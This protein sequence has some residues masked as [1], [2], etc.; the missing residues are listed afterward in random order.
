M[1]N[2]NVVNLASSALAGLISR[3]IC[4]PIDT[5]K[6]KLQSGDSF[7]GVSDVVSK[8][9]KNEGIRGFYQGMGAAL[10]GG[11]PG[12]CIYISTYEASKAYLNHNAWMGANPFIS[13]L[14]SGMAAE[15]VCCSIFVPVDVVKER[16]QVQSNR[17]DSA[18]KGS[19]DAFRTIIKQ[20]GLRGLYKGYS[21]TLFSYGPFSATYFLLYEEAK[22]K[23]A[24]G[25]SNAELSFKENLACSAFAGSVASFLT[26]P[27]DLAKLRFQVQRSVP[28]AGTTT[29][30]PSAA[31][32]ETTYTGL[33]DVLSKLY[34]QNGV[35]G[36]FR[37]ALLRVLFFTP[38]TAL[39]MASY[40]QFKVLLSKS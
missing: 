20:E 3:L 31:T 18:Y 14:L 8:T 19:I 16:L 7:R 5:C 25:K 11:I 10:F 4:H 2:E 37:G 12:V 27:L 21:A 28:T 9:L 38:S 13:Y 24:D 1:S 30:A 29:S 15:A 22:T 33:F 39:T 17:T 36:L 6:A 40:D 23:M 32:K 34:A 26:N 35:R